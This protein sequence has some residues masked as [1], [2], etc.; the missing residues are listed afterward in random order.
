MSVMDGW[1]G[2]TLGDERRT[3]AVGE[4]PGLFFSPNFKRRLFLAWGI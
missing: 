2:V 4:I 1:D 3:S